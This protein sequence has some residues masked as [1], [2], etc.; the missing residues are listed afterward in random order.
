MRNKKTCDYTRPGAEHWWNGSGED[1]DGDDRPRE[2][3]SP[4]DPR[5]S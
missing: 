1:G 4:L 5:T 2:G 3:A